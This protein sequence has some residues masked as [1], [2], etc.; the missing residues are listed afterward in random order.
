MK[1][2]ST[3][4]APQAIG[5]YSQAI[6]AGGFL[7][8]SGQIPINPAT[9]KVEESTIEGQA[10][11]VFSNIEAILKAAGLTFAH[12]V[13]SEVFLK[14]LSHFSLVNKIYGEFFTGPLQP[15]RHTVQVASLPMDALIEVTCTAYA[16]EK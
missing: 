9:G 2:I 8:L 14:D 11:Q 10:A 5:P 12:V 6:L 3:D 16:G 15:A 1:K 13:R 4:K 7:F